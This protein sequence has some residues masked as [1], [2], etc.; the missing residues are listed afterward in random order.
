VFT[1]PSVPWVFKVIRDEFPPVK[2]T[3]RAEVRSKYVMVKYHDRVG[4]MADALE[5]SDVAFPLDRLDPALL[6]ELERSCASSLARDGGR[7]VIKHLY[8]ERRMTPLDIWIRTAADDQVR[9]VVREYGQAVRE[10]AEANIFAGDLM[11]KNF[12]VTHWGRVVFYDYDEI[13]LL[14]DLRFRRLPQAQDD[15]DDMS[16]EP[17]FFVGPDDVFPEQFLPFLFPP[18]RPRDLF[19]DMHANLL[20]PAWWSAQQ[21]QIRTGV[22]PD[23]FPYPEDVRFPTGH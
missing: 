3:T 6:A 15:T 19:L 8:V 17:W 23:L 7:L 14:T 13:C 18:G 9:H 16:A 20:D 1:L 12:G 22:Q 21:E 10:L 2:N 4:R 11:L 5:Y